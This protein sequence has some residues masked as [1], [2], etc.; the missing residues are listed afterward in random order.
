MEETQNIFE[1]INPGGIPYSLL[2]LLIMVFVARF[3][4]G[5]L[6]RMEANFPDR[7]IF[8]QQLGSFGRFGI[9]L[10]GIG[11]AALS[12]LVVSNEMLLAV[13]GTAAVAIGFAMKDVAASVLA[14][15][16][17][18]LDQP[19]Q[20]GDRVTFGGYYGEIR[21]IGLRSVRM[22]TLDDTQITLPNNMILNEAVASA[23]AGAIDMM[24][25]VDLYAGLG[26]DLAEAKRIVTEAV[27]TSRFVNLERTWG[28]LISQATFETYAAVQLRAKAYV[29]DARFE[30]PFVS[31]LT[32]RV[33]E[34]WQKVGI[35]P[36]AVLHQGVGPSAEKPTSTPTT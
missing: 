14:G 10:I 6:D 27:T 33:L 28:V 35:Q 5:F 2:S 23:N 3:L 26:Q 12:S 20:V 11:F 1:F 21:H 34:H 30:K 36:P 15:V 19:F 22:M 17:I 16:I 31:D 13:G 8:I 18:L 29:L 4:T 32:E 7:R 9:Y 24:V 25:Q